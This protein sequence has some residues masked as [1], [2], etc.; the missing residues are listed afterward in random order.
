MRIS[1]E[2]SLINAAFAVVLQRGTTKLIYA[3]HTDDPNSEDDIPMHDINSMGARSVF[4]LNTFENVPELP[5][6]A[7]RV[8]R[9]QDEQGDNSICGERKLMGLMFITSAFHYLLQPFN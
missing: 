4:L 5:V 8:L 3:F 6:D 9:F 1:F 2:F 7:C